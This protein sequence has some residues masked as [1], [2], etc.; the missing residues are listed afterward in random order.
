MLEASFSE[1]HQRRLYCKRD[2]ELRTEKE[3]QPS[4]APCGSRT[5]W[6]QGTA[7]HE[8]QKWTPVVVKH[9]KEV[10]VAGISSSQEKKGARSA[11]WETATAKSCK[12]P[13][14]VEDLKQKGVLWS[15]ELRHPWV[16]W[17]WAGFSLW[18]L[19]KPLKHECS[20]YISQKVIQFPG[21]PK[22]IWRNAS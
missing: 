16:G 1:F 18:D 13:H 10:C 9:Y 3:G 4:G 22:Y 5:S 14:K 21:L 6:A 17:S 11:L 7:E 19:S 12:R 2:I 15:N 8:R 20:L